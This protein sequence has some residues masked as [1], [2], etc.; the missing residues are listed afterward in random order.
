MDHLI[1]TT[2]RTI[3]TNPK[4][5]DHVDCKLPD[6][7][8][9]LLRVALDDLEK[10]ERDDRYQVVMTSWHSPRMGGTC[11]VCFAGAV[12][13]ESCELPP[14]T[15]LDPTWSDDP[16]NKKFRALNQFRE[17]HVGHGLEILG[18]P[19]PA[20]LSNK[21]EVVSY[22]SDAQTFKDQ[23]RLLAIELQERGL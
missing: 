1:L 3:L 8:S 9:A 20:A 6:L 23:M 12:M 10:V 22:H 5:V 17:G 16:N 21:R 2:R 15:Y 19:L 4:V 18:F 11:R 13:A 14:D 7:P